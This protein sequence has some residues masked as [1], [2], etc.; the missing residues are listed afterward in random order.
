MTAR[1]LVTVARPCP[2][3]AGVGHRPHPERPGGTWPC[4]RCL[5]TG[6]DRA[7]TPLTD[8]LRALGVRFVDTTEINR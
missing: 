6:E 2:R 1:Y 8:A 7:E 5:G 3:C 4:G